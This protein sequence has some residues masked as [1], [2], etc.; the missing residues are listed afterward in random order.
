M[1]GSLSAL[2]RDTERPTVTARTRHCPRRHSTPLPCPRFLKVTFS[3]CSLTPPTHES[4]GCFCSCL[5]PG[6]PA[7]RERGKRS[8]LPPAPAWLPVLLPL[9]PGLPRGRRPQQRAEC[10]QGPLGLRASGTTGP[11]GLWQ[12]AC[13]RLCRCLV[14]GFS[15]DCVDSVYVVS[16]VSVEVTGG[17]SSSVVH[18]VADVGSR[19]LG[20]KPAAPARAESQVVPVE[21][22]TAAW[23]QDPRCAPRARGR[24]PALPA[25]TQ[26][27]R[28]AGQGRS[29]PR[30]GLAAASWGSAGGHPH[31]ACLWH[32]GRTCPSLRGTDVRGLWASQGHLWEE[33][34]RP[35]SQ[36][37]GQEDPELCPVSVSVSLRDLVFS[38]PRVTF[39][40]C[41]GGFGG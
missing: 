37:R 36:L 2:G 33:R 19:S 20:V 12:T 4:G 35:L 21:C 9:P 25:R 16:A 18:V 32:R 8:L 27:G 17:F 15:P 39:L 31:P 3:P 26:G 30:G 41:F 34:T 23:D 40:P 7:S 29:L 13:V 6:R 24:G 38:F 11:G 1:S 10:S 14:S 28:S 5:T 22:G